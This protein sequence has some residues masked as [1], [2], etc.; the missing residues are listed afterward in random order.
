MSPVIVWVVAVDPALLSM[1]PGGLD[2]TVYPVIGLPPSYAGKKVT[3]ACTLLVIAVTPVGAS[4]KVPTGATLLEAA[5]GAPTPA[6]FTALTVKVYE[7]PLVKPETVMGLAGPSANIPPGFAV[8]M[9]MVTGLPP[10][11][12][13]A[14]KATDAC[15]L[16]AVA[17]VM[18]GAVGAVAL[19]GVM[20]L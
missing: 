4:G 14:V 7:V 18:V 1:P 9:Y 8:A 10:S 12:A 11:D 17:P 5:E 6:A 15:A 3:V 2:V 16:P 19:T 20:T 13:G